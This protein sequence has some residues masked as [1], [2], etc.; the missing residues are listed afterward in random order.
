M[1][2]TT[3]LRALRLKHRI[4]LIELANV[5]GFSVQHMSRVELLQASV[6]SKMEERCGTAI[7]RLITQKYSHLRELEEDFRSMNGRLLSERIVD[8]DEL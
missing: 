3:N 5:V 2:A 6:G 1:Y 4:P 7:E 8:G